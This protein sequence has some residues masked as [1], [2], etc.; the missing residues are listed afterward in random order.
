MSGR[1]RGSRSPGRTGSLGDAS[2]GPNSGGHFNDQNAEKRSITV[3]VRSPKGLQIIKD[4]LRS[5]DIVIENFSAGVLRSWGLSFEEMSA[6]KPDL[7]YVSMAGF[8]Q[9]GPHAHYTDVRTLGAGAV[10]ADV[11]VGAARRAPR[12]VGLVVHGRHRRH[13]RLRSRR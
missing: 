13:A 4:L 5:T 3:N 12:R 8:G 2:A 10:W 7:I 11:P 1:T 9:T 6:I